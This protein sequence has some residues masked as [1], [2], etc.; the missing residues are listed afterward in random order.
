[1]IQSAGA[2]PPIG[3]RKWTTLPT[4][5]KVNDITVPPQ[6]QGAVFDSFMDMLRMVVKEDT[7]VYFGGRLSTLPVE[8][9]TL[10]D[11]VIGHSFHDSPTGFRLPVVINNEIRQ[12]EAQYNSDGVLKGIQNG[13]DVTPVISHE[14]SHVTGANHFRGIHKSVQNLDN[15]ALRPQ[16]W[17]NLAHCLLNHPNVHP[18]NTAQDTNP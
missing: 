9:G 6:Y 11:F 13:G 8:I 18:G 5:H 12:A 17:D 4:T 15:I 2:I 1:M 16:G 3:V 10:S 14:Y 7:S